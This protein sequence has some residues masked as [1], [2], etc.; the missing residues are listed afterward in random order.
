MSKHVPEGVPSAEE[1][2]A[3]L[4]N[5]LAGNKA[6][7]TCRGTVTSN[8]ILDLVAN[9]N[10]PTECCNR[11]DAFSGNLRV[12]LNQLAK[13]QRD[14]WEYAHK[15]LTM[16]LKVRQHLLPGETIPV[17]QTTPFVVIMLDPKRTLA[18]LHWLLEVNWIELNDWLRRKDGHGDAETICVSP[19]TNHLF[20][21]FPTLE[22]N[23]RERRLQGDYEGWDLTK[24]HLESV[25]SQ[26][27]EI[28]KS[29]FLPLSLSPGQHNDHVEIWRHPFCF[30]TEGH[31]RD[32]LKSFS[33]EKQGKI[34][35]WQLNIPTM[36]LSSRSIH[37]PRSQQFQGEIGFHV[38]A[39]HSK[40]KSKSPSLVSKGIS[41]G[42]G[43]MFDPPEEEYVTAYFSQGFEGQ[44]ADF[45]F[46]L[47]YY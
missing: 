28:N 44:D 43:C 35:T 29:N 20:A 8:A 31:Q 22:E 17:E 13:Y 30:V 39:E 3:H 2:V 14:G 27:P 37:E 4:M 9:S 33:R 19:I 36:L 42:L 6:F 11:W 34:A 25:L 23:T 5:K 7:A 18:L 40:W 26:F 16:Y 41:A 24:S 45:G 46:V 12:V 38:E 21:Q 15:E 10:S 32:I 47:E 1:Q